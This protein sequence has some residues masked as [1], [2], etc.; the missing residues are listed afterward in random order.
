MNYIVN[1]ERVLE[2][3][4]KTK[5]AIKAKKQINQKIKD[6]YSTR[7]VDLYQDAETRN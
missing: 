1:N 4:R 6:S 7:I 2:Q 5:N 3:I